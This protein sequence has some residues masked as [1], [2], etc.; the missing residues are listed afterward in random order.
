[1]CKFK[2]VKLFN[3][4]D[5]NFAYDSTFSL[6]STTE[7]INKQKSN[8]DTQLFWGTSI[9]VSDILIQKHDWPIKKLTW[10]DN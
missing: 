3:L 8:N 1:M 2:P 10:T 9:Q 4:K 7:Q 5:I 6:N